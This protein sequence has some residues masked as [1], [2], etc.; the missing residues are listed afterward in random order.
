MP[1]AQPS[2]A[3]QVN[4]GTPAGAPKI[5]PL[6]PNGGVDASSAGHGNS[7]SES[8][9]ATSIVTPEAHPNGLPKGPS[10]ISEEKSA[11]IPG[12]REGTDEQEGEEDDEEDEQENEE[13][14]NEDE[15]EEDDED[16]DDDDGGGE[17][18]GEGEGEED[19][20]GIFAESESDSQTSQQDEDM[21]GAPGYV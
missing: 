19:A 20:H 3:N 15:V 1:R 8:G 14:D 12:S 5:H 9:S 17:G 7:V 11:A 10:V 21:V 16:D 4:Q 13:E 18:G 2:Q 6:Y